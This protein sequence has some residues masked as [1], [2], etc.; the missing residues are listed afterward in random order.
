MVTFT[1]VCNLCTENRPLML[2]CF[3]FY[4]ININE[5]V[6]LCFIQ[7]PKALNLING[8]LPIAPIKTSKNQFF[9]NLS[10][11]LCFHQKNA[12]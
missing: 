12:V 1:T 5:F 6:E 4:C 9:G 10:S 7:V 8:M 3:S 11:N 2:P